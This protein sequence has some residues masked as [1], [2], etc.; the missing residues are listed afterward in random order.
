MSLSIANLLTMLVGR[1]PPQPPVVHS[2]SSGDDES[3]R[4][5][6]T[7]RLE[8]QVKAFIEHY[9]NN[10]GM[11]VQDFIGMTL[12]SVML[13]T[14]T[15]KLTELELMLSRFFDVFAAHD[16]K[17]ADIP[18]LLPPGTLTRA[19]L[20]NRERV[21]NA[22]NNDVLKHLSTLFKVNVSWLSG[23]SDKCYSSNETQRWYKATQGFSRRLLG[24]RLIKNVSKI[25]VVFITNEEIN[26][27]WLREAMTKEDDIRA[28][29]V[30]PI[31]IIE[32]RVNGVEL[33]SYELWAGERWNYINC[34]RDLKA[35]MLFCQRA[36]ITMDGISIPKERYKQFISEEVLIPVILQRPRRVWPIDDVVWNSDQNLELDELPAVERRFKEEKLD[37]LAEAFNRY[38]S[39]S[40]AENVAKGIELPLFD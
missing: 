8:P 9:S 27:D 3:R 13:A 23:V 30:T 2:P 26:L 29:D 5:A 17:T 1:V 21:I 32:S 31:V 20:E 25:S 15:P 35:M 39:L 7:V 38:Y 33:T 11:S 37:V 12:R 10:M 14:T 36:R 4:I 16:V 22:L 24:H 19:D 18:L 34:R 6:T 28:V 40:N